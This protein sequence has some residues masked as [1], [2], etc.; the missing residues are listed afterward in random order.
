MKLLLDTHA[1]AWYVLAN[2]KLS[3]IAQ[4]A[5]QNP[6]N[7][8]HISPASYWEL[9]IKVQ[10]GKWQLNCS[11]RSLM[12]LVLQVY[13]FRILPILP[14]HTERLINL[15][16]YHNDPFDRLLIAQA[17]AEAITIVSV[18]AHFDLYGVPRIW[19]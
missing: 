7:E 14:E 17:M 2:T 18:D 11:Y 12:D 8:I 6:S 10:L 1:M 5:I 13:G 16:D 15:P 9:C 19:S 3:A 4:S